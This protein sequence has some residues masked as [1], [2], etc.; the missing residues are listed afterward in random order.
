MPRKMKV[1]DSGTE[2]SSIAVRSQKEEMERVMVEKA[3]NL[4]HSLTTTDFL[5]W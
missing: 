3:A 1:A 5:L 2:N 4:L